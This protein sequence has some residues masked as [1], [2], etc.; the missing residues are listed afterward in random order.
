MDGSGVDPVAEGAAVAGD[1]ANVS[2][3]VGGTVGGAVGST[4]GAA[5]GAG[6]GADEGAAVAQVTFIPLLDSLAVGSHAPA[7]PFSHAND[8]A[9]S[10]LLAPTSYCSPSGP[11]TL[12]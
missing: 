11:R 12:R 10:L 3:R 9:Q 6:M 7:A 8:A 2:A 5:V 1:G 4:V